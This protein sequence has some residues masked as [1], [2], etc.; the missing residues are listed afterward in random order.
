MGAKH[1]W[2]CLMTS[3]KITASAATDAINIPDYYTKFQL[4]VVASAKSGTSPTLDVKPQISLD[5]TNYADTTKMGDTSSIGI[6][7]LTTDG[8][9]SLFFEAVAKKMRAYL[10]LGGSDTPYFTCSVWLGMIGHT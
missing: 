10:T 1:Y 6:K 2:K 9:N 8:Q 7:Q 5:G 3:T 4:K